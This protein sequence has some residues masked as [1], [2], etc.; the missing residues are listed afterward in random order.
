LS[1]HLHRQ[2]A[3]VYRTL[4][5]L[6][7]HPTNA[8]T[9]TP[10]QLKMLGKAI[11]T[12]GFTAPIL[13]D[14]SGSILAGH[15]RME[16][17]KEVG[18][19]SVP[20]IC[21]SEMTPAQKRAYIIADNRLAEL[22][23]WDRKLL[24]EEYEAIQL[25][26][27]EFD[28]ERTGFE[29]AEIEILQDGGIQVGED[30]PPQADRSKPA[31]SHLG[32][33]WLLGDHRLIC[34]DALDPSTY[35][36]LLEG[37]KAQMIITDGPFNVPIQGHVC[38]AGKVKHAEF[39]MASGEMSSTEFTAFLQTVVEHLIAHSQDGSIHFH[40]IDW[41]HI[42][43]MAAAT[44]AYSE[45]KALVVWNKT[46]A[47]MGA[48]YRSKHELIFVFKN[49]KA[50]HINNFGLGERGRYRTNVWDYAGMNSWGPDR[51]E[52]LASHPTV[53]P[54]AMIAEAIKDCS[55]KGGL[56][57]DAFG[58]SGTTMMACEATKRRA[59]LIEL[60]P[61]YVDVAIRRW[62]ADTGGKAF[63]LETGAFFSELAEKGRSA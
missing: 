20:T 63:L 22:A 37:E 33:V 8:R 42:P 44:R 16:A 1:H 32:D 46:N 23:G 26:D 34:A 31:V 49:G 10:K 24:V 40:F 35:E 7:R 15:A 19:T 50:K 56:V 29:L 60:D 11:Q 28:L 6:T 43:E 30:I 52:A 55:R 51:A 18:L 12:F 2:L 36:L 62:Q 3:V 58:G 27:P 17:A 45:F 38:G 41:R 39:V 14:E 61:Y 53:K 25:L 54:L 5:D 21:L 59:R 57:L 48:F 13:I 47:G 9:H 4:S